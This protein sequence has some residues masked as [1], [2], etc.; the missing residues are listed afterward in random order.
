[1]EKYGD[2][3]YEEQIVE[4]ILDQIRSPNKELN[5]EVNTCRPSQSSTFVKLYI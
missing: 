1:M 3:L 5:T 4:H 2:P